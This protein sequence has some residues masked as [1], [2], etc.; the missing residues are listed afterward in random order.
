MEGKRCSPHPAFAGAFPGSLC[1]KSDGRW[2]RTA[3]KQ[4]I[5]LP[6]DISMDA[7]IPLR[8]PATWLQF[9]IGL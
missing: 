8:H 6:G 7:S 9:T 3:K 4:S 1:K 5:A 2:D